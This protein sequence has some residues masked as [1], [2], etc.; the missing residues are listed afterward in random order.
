MPSRCFL[1]SLSRNLIRTRRGRFESSTTFVLASLLFPLR[2]VLG[3]TLTDDIYQETSPP[4]H[5]PSESCRV[6]MSGHCRTLISAGVYSLGCPCPNGEYSIPLNTPSN[7]GFINCTRCTHPLSQHENA[8]S[9]NPQSPEADHQISF[10]APHQGI[11]PKLPLCVE[12]SAVKRMRTQVTPSNKSFRRLSQQ[13]QI[14]SLPYGIVSKRFS[15]YM[16][17]AL[18]PVANRLSQ[19]FSKSMSQTQSLICMS[20]VSHGL[21]I[22]VAVTRIRRITAY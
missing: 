2:R 21:T 18:L 9:L 16:S 5:S 7:S 3:L 4:D 1:S 13:G 8:A 6:V 19:T 12:D 10:N 17:E 22:S 11:L 14:L 20:G 15:Y